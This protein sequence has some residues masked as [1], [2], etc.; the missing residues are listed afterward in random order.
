[1]ARCNRRRPA[2]R[3]E[4]LEERTVPANVTVADCR[5]TANA[6]AYGGAIDTG[7][8]ARL[9][10]TGC[11]FDGNF[12]SED[13]GAICASGPTTLLNT[14]VSDNGANGSGGGID[15]PFNPSN[16]SLT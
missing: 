5:I 2:L 4:A 11:T 8:L 13:G 9:T 16:P 15:K 6:A 3:L 1:M 10:V 7:A 14:T 12:A